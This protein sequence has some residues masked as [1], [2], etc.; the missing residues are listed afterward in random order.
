MFV[1]F[2]FRNINTFFFRIVKFRKQL[3]TCIAYVWFLFFFSFFF[4]NYTSTKLQFYKMF[5]LFFYTNALMFKQSNLLL[6]FVYLNDRLFLLCASLFALPC[7]L[8]VK[9]NVVHVV[10]LVCLLFLFCFLSR[11]KKFS[12]LHPCH[13]PLNRTNI[14]QIFLFFLNAP[15]FFLSEWLSMF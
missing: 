4:I 13:R 6:F 1:C 12:G 7:I 9:T 10:S 11:V 2:C 14:G 3:F 5:P 15:L 8:Q